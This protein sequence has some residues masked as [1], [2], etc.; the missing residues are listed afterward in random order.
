MPYKRLTTTKGSCTAG[1]VPG[2]CFPQ[3]STKN[4]S[5]GENMKSLNDILAKFFD[6]MTTPGNNDA[7]LMRWAKV[8]YGKHWKQAY[9]EM[10]A[11][12]GVVPRGENI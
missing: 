2:Y 1:E 5:I 7:E 3:A 9:T 10:K 12:P 8:E 6:W 11:N 4:I